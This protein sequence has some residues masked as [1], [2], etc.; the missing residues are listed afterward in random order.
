MSLVRQKSSLPDGTQLPKGLLDAEAMINDD[1]MY[2]PPGILKGVTSV[3][4]VLRGRTPIDESISFTELKAY[5]ELMG[6]N[7]SP[8]EVEVI[9]LLDS[10]YQSQ[11]YIEKE[12]GQ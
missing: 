11:Y 10:T 9:L 5:V 12:K 3:F 2:K 8:R 7:I 4:W 1:I 6:I